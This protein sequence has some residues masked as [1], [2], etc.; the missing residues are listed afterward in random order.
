LTKEGLEFRGVHQVDEATAS[1][2][3]IDS[4]SADF[5]SP[6]R[7]AM[8]VSHSLQ[9]VGTEFVG[10]FVDIEMFRATN[11][12]LEIGIDSRTKIFPAGEDRG[13]LEILKRF[14]F[15]H[16]RMYMS[17]VS[18]SS[19]RDSV[20]VFLKG[21]YERIRELADPDSLPSDYDEQAEKHAG[22][23][24]YVL[25]LAHKAVTCEGGQEG[26]DTIL[27]MDRNDLEKSARFI[28]FMLFRNELKSDSAE[29]LADLKGGGIRTIMITGD[30]ANTACY[31]ARQSGM[32]YD[33]PDLR[34][35]NANV[36]L[37]DINKSTDRVEWKMIT[38]GGSSPK[39]QIVS[40]SDLC[41]LLSTSRLGGKQT[42]LAVTGKAFNRLI[43]QGK[44]GS[45]LLGILLYF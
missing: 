28:G 22:D 37:A 31:I 34:C 43:S 5:S 8:E 3:S 11:A 40:V 33:G 44:M 15:V 20:D 26:I 1:F 6:I 45:Y 38:S 10:N 27:D 14:E 41:A 12:R 13:H 30:N 2:Q 21:S 17:V 18:K 42:E 16:A 32:L 4:D 9:L 25:A 19:I 39:K 35:G 23:G 24:Y 7:E 29:A 36:V